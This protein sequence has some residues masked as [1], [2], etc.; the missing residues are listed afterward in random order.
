M[1]VS[2]GREL[3]KTITQ[4]QV[5]TDPYSTLGALAFTRLVCRMSAVD[6]VHCILLAHARIKVLPHLA[7][8]ATQA[9]AWG[10]RICVGT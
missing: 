5:Q 4:T 3:F 10:F 7:G 2:K 8:A 6:K 9:H 1:W